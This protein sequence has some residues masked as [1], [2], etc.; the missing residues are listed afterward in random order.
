MNAVDLRSPHGDTLDITAPA[1]GQRLLELIDRAD[2]AYQRYRR[3]VVERA[4]PTQPLNCAQLQAVQ[5][6]QQAEQELA[7]YRQSRYEASVSVRPPL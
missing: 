2:T 3:F 4:D 1:T 7:D 6:Y 5:E